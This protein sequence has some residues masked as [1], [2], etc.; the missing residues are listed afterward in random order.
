MKIYSVTEVLPFDA[1]AI[2][3]DVLANACKRGSAVHVA[4]ASY[5]KL[6]YAMRL[7]DDWMGYYNSFLSWYESNVD[8]ALM[9]EQRITDKK[10]G[11]TGRPDFVFYMKTGEVVL[12]DIKTPL[13]EQPTWKCQLAAYDHLVTEIAGL[14]LD[15]IL[16]LRLHPEGGAAKGIRYNGS[17]AAAFNAF[18]SALNAHRF[19]NG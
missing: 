15:D 10:L 6:G 9:V 1:N 19:I 2:P 17:K 3:D 7:P 16:S 5:T 4:C 14:K 18:L 8:Q 11:F 12:T 13:A